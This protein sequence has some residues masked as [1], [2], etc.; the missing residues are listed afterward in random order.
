M[1]IAVI[2]AALAVGTSLA[3]AQE[4]TTYTDPI[5]NLAFSYP[6][7]WTVSKKTKRSVTFTIPISGSGTGTFEV[8]HASFRAEP[9][10]WQKIQEHAVSGNGRRLVRQWDQQVLDT[11]MLLTQAEYDEAG[12]TRTELTGLYYTKSPVKLL[13]HF[14]VPTTSFDDAQL[15]F[16]KMLESLHTV[17]GSTPTVED[18]NAPLPAKP[19]KVEPVAKKVV[20]SGEKGEGKAEP[21]PLSAEA[22]VSTRKVLLRY[23]DGWTIPAP[24]A[25]AEAPPEGIVTLKNGSVSGPISLQ[26]FSSLDSEPYKN[27]LFRVSSVSLN[28]YAKVEK[29][30]DVDDKTNKAGSKV[31]WVWRQGTSASG[32][33]VTLEAYVASGDYYLIATY[34]LTDPKRFDDERK[35]IEALIDRLSIEPAP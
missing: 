18:P 24:A 15:Q 25:G 19:E 31:G 9:D 21:A 28:D 2:V 13:F 12:A 4:T 1:K 35:A 8:I 22:I 6:K 29:R 30:F 16:Q 7:D 10:L 20:L 23:P 26:L 34:R 5:L 11:P 33:L 32:P 27:A 14:D 3:S 17:D